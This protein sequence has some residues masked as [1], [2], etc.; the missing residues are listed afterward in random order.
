MNR[1]IDLSINHRVGYF[2]YRGKGSCGRV[3]IQVQALWGAVQAEQGQIDGMNQNIGIR[4]QSETVKNDK[5]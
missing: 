5:K 1:L 2:R 3:N 4:H